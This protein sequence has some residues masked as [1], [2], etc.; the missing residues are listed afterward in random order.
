MNQ[1]VHGTYHLLNGR[2][3]IVAV[4]E[5]E[6]EVVR[7]QPA[8]R[9]VH[10]FHDVFA[11]QPR[12]VDVVAHPPAGLAG[13]HQILAANVQLL[14]DLPDEPFRF[15]IGVDVGQI[16]EVDTVVKRRLH[17]GAR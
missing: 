12:V 1:V 10:R 9:V 13:D 7:I 8:Q 6:V 15:A 5:V 4:A 11:A 2:L 17:A 14:D 3:R 16:D